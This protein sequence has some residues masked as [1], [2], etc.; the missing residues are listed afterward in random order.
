MGTI[1]KSFYLV[2]SRHE[3]CKIHTYLYESLCGQNRFTFWLG[4]YAFV[5]NFEATKEG[6]YLIKMLE[7]AR[8]STAAQRKVDDILT[9][10]KYWVQVDNQMTEILKI[11]NQNV[12]ED[13]HA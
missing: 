9:R 13:N 7:H 4:P 3:Y 10:F 5:N 8:L 12:G 2:N 11:R 6:K 1:S